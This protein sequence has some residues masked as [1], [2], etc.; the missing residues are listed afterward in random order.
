MSHTVVYV[1]DVF[2]DLTLTDNVTH[3]CVRSRRVS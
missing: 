3:Y 2:A 1:V